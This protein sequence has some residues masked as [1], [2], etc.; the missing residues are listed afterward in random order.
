MPH[1]LGK[2]FDPSDRYF[3]TDDRIV[4]R[5]RKSASSHRKSPSTRAA[6]PAN[7]HPL[8]RDRTLPSSNRP[9]RKQTILR[10]SDIAIAQLEQK[11]ATTTNPESQRRYA[12]QLGKLQL[13]HPLAIE[14]LLQLMLASHPASFYKRT[15]EYI[16]E[17]ATDAQLVAIAIGLKDCERAIENGD[18]SSSNLER[19]KLLWYCTERLPDR[20]FCHIWKASR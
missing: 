11:L 18:R 8:V 19:Y 2:V 13:G 14:I 1:S 12:Y 15:G 3:S 9:R 17:I 7:Q 6:H 5:S 16:R 10:N 4:S 20:T